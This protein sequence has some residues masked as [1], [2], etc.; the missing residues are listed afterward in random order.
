[1]VGASQ[2]P[3]PMLEA[4]SSSAYISCL[5]DMVGEKTETGIGSRLLKSPMLMTTIFFFI[6]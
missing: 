2:G 5:I 3:A 1:M 4:P 6:Y